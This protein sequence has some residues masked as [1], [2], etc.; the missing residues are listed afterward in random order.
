MGDSRDTNGGIHQSGTNAVT[1]QALARDAQKAEPRTRSAFCEECAGDPFAGAAL[2]FRSIGRQPTVCAAVLIQ[3]HPL[4]KRRSESA[5]T[6][7][8]LPLR[9]KHFI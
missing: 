9:R 1:P 7:S 4:S 5:S 6:R 3:N 8:C 2:H